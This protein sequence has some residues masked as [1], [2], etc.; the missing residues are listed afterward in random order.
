MEMTYSGAM[1]MPANFAVVDEEEMTY[2]DGGGWM[3]DIVIGVFS[4]LIY[5]AGKWAFQKV[6]GTAA[7][8]AV[9]TSVIKGASVL[10]ALVK[11]AVVFVW[12]HIAQIAIF[13]AGVATGVCL[14]RK[15]M[16]V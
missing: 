4:A 6:A 10:W 7:A 1:V 14:A 16:G 9:I 5:D 12:N 8:K 3:E 13:A 2:L 11:A 15:R